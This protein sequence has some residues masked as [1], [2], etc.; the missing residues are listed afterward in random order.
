MTDS[1]LK[2]LLVML[3]QL[4]DRKTLINTGRFLR[5]VLRRFDKDKGTRV[6]ASLS[7]SS[8]LAIV[9]MMTIALALMSAFPGFEDSRS[10]LQNSLLKNILPAA[11]LEIAEQLNSFVANAQ[12]MTAIGVLALAVTAIMLLY[13]IS[14]SFNSIWC[15]QERRPLFNLI[16]VYWALLTLGPLLLGASL[17]VSSYG[18]AMAELVGG[19]SYTRSFVS[20]ILPIVLGGTAFTLL[21]LVVPNRPVLF[22]HALAGGVAAT[23]LFELLKR[24]FGLYLS[25]FPSYQAIYGAMATIPIFLIWM[26]LSWVVVLLGAEIAAALPERRAV[27]RRGIRREGIGDY[28]SLMIA[29][30]RKLEKAG[31]HGTSLKETVMMK[32]LPADLRATGEVLY[33]LKRLR[34][35]NRT[36]RGRWILCRDLSAVTLEDLLKE[37]DLDYL[38]RRNWPEGIADVLRALEENPVE[39]R[40]K[41]LKEILRQSE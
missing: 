25:Y 30:L 34:I 28:L 2:R 26:Y 17:T 24:G 39:V 20:R 27:L 41:S 19:G 40:K 9:P 38:P 1:T 6:A 37:L 36:G 11:E 14:H 23:T 4:A 7:Y 32:G 31:H 3:K 16:L 35:A 8:L 12:N 22:K 21:Y 10:T 18:F 5:Y 13:T 15:V 33:D 29:L